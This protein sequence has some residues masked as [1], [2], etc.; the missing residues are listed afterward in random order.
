MPPAEQPG[1]GPV[2]VDAGSQSAPTLPQGQQ[3]LPANDVPLLR[4]IGQVGAAYIVAEGRVGVYCQ[5]TPERSERV[6]TL[7]PGH[8]FGQVAL[9]DSRGRT[10][11]CRALEPVYLVR[12]PGDVYR[13]LETETSPEGRAFRRGMIDALSVQLRLANEHLLTLASRSA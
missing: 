7:G 2:A 11:T 1:A 4:V 10:A 5:V 8:V 3:P 13:A 9:A 12:I 6:A